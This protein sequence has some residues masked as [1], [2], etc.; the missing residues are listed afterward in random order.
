[1]SQGLFFVAQMSLIPGTDSTYV[2]R[3]PPGRTK[4]LDDM[5]GYQK[6]EYHHKKLKDTHAV[7]RTLINNKRT[8]Q[9]VPKNIKNNLPE[10]L[11]THGK[12]GQ[13]PQ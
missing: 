6:K 8:E 10:K 9:Q 1:M 3:R 2:R 13:R 4:N 11:A 7:T 5:S 12:M